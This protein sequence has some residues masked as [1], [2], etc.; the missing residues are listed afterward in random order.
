MMQTPPKTL[1]IAALQTGA[2]SFDHAKIDYYISIAKTK[3]CKLFVLG[4]YMV[5]LFFKEL[6]HSP[7]NFIKD[8]CNH[9]K[10]ALKRLAEVYNITIVAPMVEVQ[11]EQVFK[12]IYKFA[13]HSTARYLQQ[14]LIHYKHWNEEAFFA[15]PIAPLESPLIFNVEGIRCALFAGFEM[16]FDHFWQEAFRKKAD[17]VILPTASTF[18]SASRWRQLLSAK[19]FLH[20]LYILR[21]NRIGIYHDTK[22]DWEFYGDSFLVGPSGDVELSLGRK[23]ELL[24]TTIERDKVKFCR[25]NWGFHGSLHKRSA[26]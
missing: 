14:I 16:H 6:E 2:L 24:I 11:G 13:P 10:N 23:E 12:V 1:N 8:Q 19:A 25:K 18:E 4:E 20:Q 5:N 3:K 26:L 15:N 9:Q 22:A 7:L 21:V 17:L